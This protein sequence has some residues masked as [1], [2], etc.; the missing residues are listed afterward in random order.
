MSSAATIS[1][2]E[3]RIDL[4]RRNIA[5]L[6]EQAAAYS[7]AAD[8][9]RISDR[10]AQQEEELAKLIALRDTDRGQARSERDGDEPA[11]ARPAPTDAGA[12]NVRGRTRPFVAGHSHGS[13]WGARRNWCSRVRTRALIPVGCLRLCSFWAHNLACCRDGMPRNVSRA[14]Y[15]ACGIRRCGDGR[16]LY[17]RGPGA[18]NRY[19]TDHRDDCERHNAPTHARCV[20]Y[21]HAC[22]D[23]A[24]QRTD[25]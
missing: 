18:A 20:F 5:E 9:A 1:E 2:L 8:D 19:R 22:A 3:E 14:G 25:L 21:G 10:I 4:V 15:S 13:T 12:R 24:S 7:G 16:I 6:V 17:G 11:D 23:A